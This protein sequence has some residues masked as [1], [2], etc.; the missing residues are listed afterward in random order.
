MKII[1][2]PIEISGRDTLFHAVVWRLAPEKSW[3]P[4]SIIADDGQTS[5]PKRD[6]TLN[7]WEH[8]S[9]A[10]STRAAGVNRLLPNWTEMDWVKRLFWDDEQAVIQLQAPRSQWVSTA[11]VLHLWRPIDRDIPLPPT[12]MVGAIT[13]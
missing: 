13:G 3:A 10:V 11:E 4:W 9:V 8:V 5:H 6:P 12:R 1:A 2:L 7:G